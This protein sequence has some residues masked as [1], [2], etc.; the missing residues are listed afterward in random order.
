MIWLNMTPKQFLDKLWMQMMWNG[1]SLP[2]NCWLRFFIVL[3]CNGRCEKVR[4]FHQFWFPGSWLLFHN[5]LLRNCAGWC[6]SLY[7]ICVLGY[8]GWQVSL[9][10]ELLTQKAAGPLLW[11]PALLDRK[12]NENICKFLSRTMY[13]RLPSSPDFETGIWLV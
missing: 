11:V 3:S 5:M 7:V 4:L 10:E 1:V 13:S 12:M 6:S 2:S 8:V 9:S